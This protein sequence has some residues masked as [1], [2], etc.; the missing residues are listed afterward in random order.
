MVTMCAPS[1]RRRVVM[2]GGGGDDD[3]DDD[4]V[5]PTLELAHSGTASISFCYLA[6]HILL[7]L[8]NS[9]LEQAYH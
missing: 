2:L 1:W 6:V 5:G 3:D 9:L 8:L 4:D 7:S